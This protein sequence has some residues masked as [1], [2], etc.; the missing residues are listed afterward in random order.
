[1]RIGIAECVVLAA[2]GYAEPDAL[3]V[4]GMMRR[5]GVAQ[6]GRIVCLIFGQEAEA[7]AGMTGIGEMNAALGFDMRSGT[8]APNR[9]Y[10]VTGRHVGNRGV[11]PEFVHR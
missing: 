5:F 2:F 9:E 4:V 10:R 1:M 11:G 8:V 7:D 6:F 3:G